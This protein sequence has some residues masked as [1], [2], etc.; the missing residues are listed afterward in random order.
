MV[1]V[2][3]LNKTMDRLQTFHSDNNDKTP[4]SETFNEVM[5]LVR[6]QTYIPSVREEVEVAANVETTENQKIC[7]QQT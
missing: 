3:N 6:E 2:G 7:L 4:Y 5:N 1:G